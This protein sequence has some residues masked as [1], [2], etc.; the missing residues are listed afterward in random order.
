MTF[1]DLSAQAIKAAN[2]A[3]EDALEQVA[4]QVK[5]E[6]RRNVTGGGNATDRL[7]VRSSGGL[8]LRASID[9]EVDKAGMASKARI[10]ASVKYAA[11][12]EF[13]GTIHAKNA[14]YLHF[15]TRDGGWVRTKQVTIPARP[16]LRPAL[17]EHAPALQRTFAEAMRRRMGG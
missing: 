3:A 16:Y 2:R 4:R 9:H 8:G 10:G 13:G 17:T 1:I 15:K 11:I 14:E 6:A 5:N 7:N 12:H